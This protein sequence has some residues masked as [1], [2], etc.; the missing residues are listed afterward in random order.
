[1][2]YSARKREE[3][4]SQMEEKGISPFSKL[5]STYL[6]TTLNAIW[7]EMIS[8]QEEEFYLKS[9]NSILRLRGSYYFVYVNSNFN[10]RGPFSEDLL[11]NEYSFCDILGA[12]LKTLKDRSGHDDGISFEK[13]LN[14]ILETERYDKVFVEGK[15]VPNNSSIAN[16]GLKNLWEIFI[17]KEKYDDV[18]SKFFEAVEEYSNGNYEDCIT[19]VGTAVQS[20][21][22][23]HGFI[24]NTI[25]EQVTKAVNSGK[26]RKK[27]DGN[28]KDQHLW[29]WIRVVRNDDGDAHPDSD[30]SKELAWS[31]LQI[32]GS[33]MERYSLEWN[34]S[35]EEEK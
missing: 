17:E 29:D 26:I 21:L 1:M 19:D 24:G 4:F 6:L 25:G 31:Y 11:K 18:R 15:L 16:Q 9:I 10:A 23:I 8:Y 7:A 3:N 28:T 20:F 30:S 34:D 12:W 27:S 5:P 35:F 13:L 2:V 33:V 14:S 32:V 22:T